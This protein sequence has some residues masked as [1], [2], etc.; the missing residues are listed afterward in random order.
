MASGAAFEHIL[1]HEAGGVGTLN[2]NRPDR[3]NA[4]HIPCLEEILAVLDKV[5][6]RDELRCLLITGVG[7]AFCAGADLAAGPDGGPPDPGVILGD[8]INPLIMRLFSLPVPVVTA[9]NG[10]AAGAGCSLALAG[11][12]VIA[13]HSA[14]FVQAFTGLGLVPDAG[15]SWLLPRLIGRARAL[16]MMLLAEPV[17]AQTALDWGLVG[18]LAEDDTLMADASAM[19][20]RLANGPTRALAM[21]RH[22]IHAAVTEELG[23]SLRAEC[24][25]QVAA[26]QTADFREGLMAFRE[27]R[28]PDFTGK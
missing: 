20:H 4:L 1:W 12:I 16:R 19:A 26:G 6:Q 7:R 14:T 25:D 2:I 8:Y 27:K 23:D 13:A 22:R 28:K 15:S 3:A 18:F 21:V 5:Q 11:D 24:A 9:V 17:P 10:P